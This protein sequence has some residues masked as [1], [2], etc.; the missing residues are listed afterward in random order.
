MTTIL[1]PSSTPA[2]VYCSEGRTQEAVS[3]SAA[4]IDSVTIPSGAPSI[5]QYAHTTIVVVTSSVTAGGV[6][7]PASSP[8][9]SV[10]EAFVD[11]GSAHGALVYPASGDTIQNSNSAV[12]QINPGDSG[13]FQKVG[14]S[15]WR[16]RTNVL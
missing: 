3:T 10:V 13:R 2:V 7:L 9:G 8:I 11:Y 14:T 15:D 16:Y 6:V 4:N 12:G 5:V 1:N